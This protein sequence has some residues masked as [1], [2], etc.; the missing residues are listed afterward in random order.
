MVINI[1]LG[2]MLGFMFLGLAVVAICI[3]SAVIIRA[4]DQ[5]SHSKPIRHRTR[6]ETD[7]YNEMQQMKARAKESH[8]EH[9]GKQ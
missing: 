3:V 5:I 6:P 8:P 4:Q 7:R 9:W 1:A 2:V